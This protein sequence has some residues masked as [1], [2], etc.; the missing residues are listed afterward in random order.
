MD[1]DILRCQA[2]IQL[3]LIIIKIMFFIITTPT[4]LISF[5]SSSSSLWRCQVLIQLGAS[6]RLALTHFQDLATNPTPHSVSAFLVNFNQMNSSDLRKEKYKSQGQKFSC[7]LILRQS[8]I[9][10]R[11]HYSGS[12]YSICSLMSPL[13]W[14]N[15]HFFNPKWCFVQ[16]IYIWRFPVGYFNF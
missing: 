7:T 2:L 14:N 10:K 3:L 16:L 1:V 11:V 13:Q 8:V 12:P 15:C 6:C 5:V 4:I 9:L